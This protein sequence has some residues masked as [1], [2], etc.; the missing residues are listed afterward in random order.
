MRRLPSTPLAVTAVLASLA[1][2]APAG[3]DTAPTPVSSAPQPVTGPA[4]APLSAVAGVLDTAAP[5]LRAVSYRR[6]VLRLAV[7]EPGRLEIHYLRMD[8]LAHVVETETVGAR[9]GDNALALR[10][11]MRPGRYRITVDATDALGNASRP[12]HLKLRVRR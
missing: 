11:W 4:A 3:A 9:A 12:L 6:N 1:L 2:A 7:S 8:H 5:A 10:R